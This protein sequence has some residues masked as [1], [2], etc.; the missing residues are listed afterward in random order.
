M[1]IAT[2]LPFSS[3]FFHHWDLEGREMGALIV[4]GSFHINAGD[5]SAHLLRPPTGDCA[6][7]YIL[8]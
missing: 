4:K 3:L 7:R 2:S 8:C 5:R 1:Q 6:C